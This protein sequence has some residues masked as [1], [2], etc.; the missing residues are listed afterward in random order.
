MTICQFCKDNRG[1]NEY[2]YARHTVSVFFSISLNPIVN[3]FLGS[4]YC[5]CFKVVDNK[6]EQLIEGGCESNVKSD[7]VKPLINVG[8]DLLNTSDMKVLNILGRTTLV[9]EES[10]K[11]PHKVVVGL[12]RVGL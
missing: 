6:I 10:K 11:I 5:A 4:K 3:S 2:I 7:I 8:A 1:Y 9:I 12:F